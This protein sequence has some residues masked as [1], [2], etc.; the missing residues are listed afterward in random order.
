[1]GLTQM[2]GAV[3]LGPPPV[4]VNVLMVVRNGVTDT[5]RAVRSMVA[6]TAGIG[7]IL[8]WN[9]ASSDTTGDELCKIEQNGDIAVLHAPRKMGF[10]YAFDQIGKFFPGPLLT[11]VVR[12]D[13]ILP[14]GWLH[15]MAIRYKQLYPAGALCGMWADWNW[16]DTTIT[17]SESNGGLGAEIYPLNRFSGVTWKPRSMKREEPP[18]IMVMNAVVNGATKDGKLEPRSNIAGFPEDLSRRYEILRR[19][20]AAMPDVRC[21]RTSPAK[22][23]VG[24]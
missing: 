8:V 7:S 2:A 13:A 3:P 23:L 19:P 24:G 4:L 10:E 12:Q 14:P 16:T 11:A 5:M 9:D 20:V 21:G 18:V 6:N 17:L 1:M 15:K 22:I